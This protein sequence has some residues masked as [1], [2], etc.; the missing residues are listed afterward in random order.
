LGEFL[1]SSPNFISLP[2]NPDEFEG[3]L[4]LANLKRTSGDIFTGSAGSDECFDVKR[5]RSLE[6]SSKRTSSK[7]PFM[8][9][10]TSLDSK[11]VGELDSEFMINS[12]DVLNFFVSSES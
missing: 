7:L 9:G 2:L 10:S 3:E 12:R 5:G 6:I 11:P 8:P 1:E 4:L